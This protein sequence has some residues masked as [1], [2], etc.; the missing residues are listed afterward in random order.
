MFYGND[1]WNNGSPRGMGAERG[2]KPYFRP[3]RDGR[4]QLRGVPV[5]NSR[6]WD[7]AAAG[8]APVRQRLAWY[9]SERSHLFALVRAAL[10][11]EVSTGEQ[12]AFYGGLYGVDET[13][14]FTA[15]WD[16][17][18]RLLAEFAARIRQS[19]ARPLLVYAPSIAQVEE[20]HWR[21][22][23]DLHGLVG[24]YDLSKPNRLLAV[25]AARH[26]LPFVDLGPAFAQAPESPD[27][28]YGDSHW[29]PAGHALAARVLAEVL[30]G[31]A[32]T[33]PVERPGR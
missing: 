20:G 32:P 26:D 10:S 27:L 23:R 29:T 33:R 25:I 4:L 18:A 8:R 11:P 30:A 5:P 14:E 24:E 21:A 15:V 7:R 9:L 3:T 17:S 2:Y 16:L 6:F 22:K 31:Q 28:Y 12:R 19:G 13:G 1:L